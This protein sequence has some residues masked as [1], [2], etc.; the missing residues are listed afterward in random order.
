MEDVDK[1]F[2][3][4]VAKTYLV[5]KKQ[6]DKVDKALNNIHEGLDALNEKNRNN[7]DEL[8]KLLSE[9]MKLCNGN[10]ISLNELSKED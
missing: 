10:E 4:E 3:D 6:T 1:T 8:D 9:A 5:R 2:I 7:N